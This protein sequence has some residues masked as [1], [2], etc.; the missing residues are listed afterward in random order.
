MLLKASKSMDRDACLAL[1][2][3]ERDERALRDSTC[4]GSGRQSRL[5]RMARTVRR[6]SVRRCESRRLPQRA[7]AQVLSVSTRTN[8]WGGED[9]P[10]YQRCR[11]GSAVVPVSPRV[12]GAPTRGACPKASF[13]P[14]A[15]ART[16][17]APSEPY[18]A[19]VGCLSDGP[20]PR[21]GVPVRGIPDPVPASNAAVDGSGYRRCSLVAGR[22]DP[23]PRRTTAHG[24]SEARPL[25]ARVCRANALWL[26]RASC[27]PWSTAT[28]T[29]EPMRGLGVTA[30]NKHALDVN[31]VH[32][33]G[34]GVNP[35]DEHDLGV[36]AFD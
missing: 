32:N 20:A 14:R 17:V 35:L 15:A 12:R 5:R 8:R 36:H 21:G 16:P 22:D 9:G 10:R 7:V 24:S 26:R 31:P 19:K 25:R 11:K 34:L 6:G 28:A 30:V 13:Q 23:S 4:P 18:A 27:L 1:L 29:A 2:E 3:H 33:L